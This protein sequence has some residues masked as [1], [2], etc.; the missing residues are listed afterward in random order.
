VAQ[1]LRK[2]LTEGQAQFDRALTLDPNDDESYY[3]RAKDLALQGRRTR[4]IQDLEAAVTIDPKLGQAF[5]ELAELYSG[6]GQPTK[7]SLMREKASSLIGSKS[8]D[9]IEEYIRNLQNANP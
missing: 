1:L 5:M 8:P 9:D 6:D 3:W 4:A 7:A 2:H